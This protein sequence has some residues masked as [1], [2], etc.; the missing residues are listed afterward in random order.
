M[1]KMK[2]LAASLFRFPVPFKQVFPLH[3]LL[4]C[5]VLVSVDLISKKIVTNDLNF[6]LSARQFHGETPNPTHKALYDGK[7]QI[8]LIGEEGAI[9][10]FRLIFNDHFVFG[11]GPSIP[12]F[13]FFLTSFAVLFL[14]FFRWHN[15][16]VGHPVAWL[17]VFSGAFGNL[18]DKM[19]IK[20]LATR[21]WVF[22]LTPRPGYVNGVVDFI[23]AIWFGQSGLADNR[24]LH[25]LSWETWP[26]FNLADSFVVVGISL[27][28][29]TMEYGTGEEKQAHAGGN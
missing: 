24:L 10:K 19:F 23:E 9:L 2:D 28:V 7:D 22:S 21:E 5:L 14:F 6:F 29:L 17:L 15:H 3:W 16:A 11:L 13:G 1:I 4:L 12:Q 8:N 18:I 26:S 25:F 27:L 20:S